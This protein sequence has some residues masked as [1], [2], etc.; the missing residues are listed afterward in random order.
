MEFVMMS[1][2]TDINW[3]YIYGLSYD[4][5]LKIESISKISKEGLITVVNYIISDVD[6]MSVY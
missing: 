2:C 5:C 4:S 6:L 1:D 3:G